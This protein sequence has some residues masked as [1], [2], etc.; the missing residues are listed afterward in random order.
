[1]QSGK[2]HLAAVWNGDCRG[3]GGGH[4]GQPSYGAAAPVQVRGMEPGYTRG[5]KSQASCSVSQF[6]PQ[7]LG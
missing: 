7:T 1:M 6:P 3:E 2:G 4:E 5:W